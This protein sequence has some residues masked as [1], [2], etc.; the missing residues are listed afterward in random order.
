MGRIG[1]R[2]WWISAR[3]FIDCF[4]VCMWLLVGHVL[5][6]GMC[7]SAMWRAGNR[8]AIC[9]WLTLEHGIGGVSCGIWN[10]IRWGI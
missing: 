3:C 10:S 8:C 7:G 6:S 9:T 5:G 1:S 4:A 2:I